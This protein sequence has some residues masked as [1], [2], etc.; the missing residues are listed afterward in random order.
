M[1]YTIDSPVTGLRAICE[2]I[3]RSLPDWFGRAD[4]NL[5]YLEYVDA[6]PTFLIRDGAQA[7]GFLALKQHYP[8]SAEIYIMAVL[9][10]Y[11]RKGVGR[12]LVEAAVAHLRNSGT[13]FLQVK[14]L[15]AEHPDEG[16]Q[17][18]R[19]FYLGVGFI[20]LEEHEDLWGDIP[21]LQLVR[22]LGERP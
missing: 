6:N 18:T 15:G 10:D 16:Y 21:A 12:S 5:H 9:P 7:V 11:H 20:P 1:P 4:A 13:L 19:L 14:T 8:Q 2:P 17:R 3:L 22:Y